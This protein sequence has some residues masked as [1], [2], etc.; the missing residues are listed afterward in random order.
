MRAVCDAA[1]LVALAAPTAAQAQETRNVR[2]NE[3]NKVQAFGIFMR[4]CLA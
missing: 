1:V 4:A 2:S 3:P